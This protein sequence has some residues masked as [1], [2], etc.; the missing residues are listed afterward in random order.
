M[1]VEWYTPFNIIDLAREVL[2]VINV[3]PA[4][5]LIAQEWIKADKF[6]TKDTNGLDKPWKGKNDKT[7][8]LVP[9]N[10]EFIWKVII[11]NPIQGEKSEYKGRITRI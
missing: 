11:S 5:N 8:E 2:G 9:E 7:D 6:Y 4:S 3:D 10:S 1:E